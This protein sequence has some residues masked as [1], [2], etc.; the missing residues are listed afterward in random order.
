MCATCGHWLACTLAPF[1]TRQQALPFAAALLQL[2]LT[3]TCPVHSRI[4]LLEGIVAL[5][6][7]CLVVTMCAGFPTLLRAV[8]SYLLMQSAHVL[9]WMP[10]RS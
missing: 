7:L 10:G 5:Q 6:G 8:V 2:S 9:S 4:L 3:F 1:S